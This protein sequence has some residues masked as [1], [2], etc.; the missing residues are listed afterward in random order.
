[1]SKRREKF[2]RRDLADNE[3]FVRRCSRQKQIRNKEGEI[4]GISWEAFALRIEINETYLSGA[5][6][7][8]HNG[9]REEQL[10]E[11]VRSMRATGLPILP[12]HVLA[13]CN[14]GAVRGCGEQRSRTLRVRHEPNKKNRAYATIRELP[15][16]NADA[17]LLEILAAESVVS[18]RLAS[19][20]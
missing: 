4:I 3:H 10:K 13:A 11:C 14:A 20:L 6:L 8:H 2:P 15:L 7:E 5:F 12:Q 17:E 19:S 9:S 1:M 18:I 16:D